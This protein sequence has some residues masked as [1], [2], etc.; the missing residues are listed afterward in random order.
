MSA[1]QK[2]CVCVADRAIRQNQVPQVCTRYPLCTIFIAKN[3]DKS[4]YTEYAHM[5]YLDGSHLLR[6][7]CPD[8]VRQA[9]GKNACQNIS[10]GRQPP[11]NI[12]DQ[13]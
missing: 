1:A 9:R 8:V 3:L 6:F 7:S 2:G 12:N 4:L 13:R 5:G 11:A 10:A